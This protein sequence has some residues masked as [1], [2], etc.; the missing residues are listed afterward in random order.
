MRSMV[1]AAI[2]LAALGG[3]NKAP[4]ADASGEPVKPAPTPAAKAVAMKI[5]DTGFLVSFDKPG[6][7]QLVGQELQRLQMQQ[8]DLTPDQL[9]AISGGLRKNVEAAVPQMKEAM[10]AAL[11]D[12]FTSGS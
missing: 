1:L 10:Q 9:M 8:R 3:C 6:V 2:A 12:S 5:I 11:T 7:D 4:A